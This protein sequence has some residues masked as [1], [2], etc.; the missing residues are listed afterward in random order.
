MTTKIIITS[1]GQDLDLDPAEAPLTS[2]VSSVNSKTGA[3]TLD[4]D[5]IEEGETNLYF[6]HERVLSTVSYEGD[7]DGESETTAPTQKATKLAIFQRGVKTKDADY[8]VLLDD[9]IIKADATSAAFTLTLPSASLAVGRTYIISKIDSTFNAISITGAETIDLM[10]TRKLVTKGETIQLFSDGTAWVILSR[11]IPS[12]L[13]TYTPTFSAGFGTVT[14]IGFYWYR[15]GQCIVIQGKA[16]AGTV[17][18]TVG[19]ISLPTGLSTAD[20]TVI[21]TIRQFG[22]YYNAGSSTVFFGVAVIADPSATF[23]NLGGQ[24]S[25]L[26]TFSKANVSA[27]QNPSVAFSINATIPILDWDK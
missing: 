7:L 14:G 20:V 9:R 24:T 15:Q 6:T 21:P 8:T 16:T 1:D 18:A 23:L 22:T 3:A 12:T 25:T 27:I 10:A 2:G 13:N 17:A 4:T 26:N 5:D 11:H 19:T